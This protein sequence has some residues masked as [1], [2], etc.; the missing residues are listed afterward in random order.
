MLTNHCH[1]KSKVSYITLNG[2]GLFIILIINLFKRSF[3]QITNV[4]ADKNF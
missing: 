3:R 1:R 2:V 4:Y